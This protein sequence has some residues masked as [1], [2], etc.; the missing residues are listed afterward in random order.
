MILISIFIQIN[1][2]DNETSIKK[3]MYLMIENIKRQNNI[4]KSIK[5]TRKYNHV[6]AKEFIAQSI[7]S[8]QINW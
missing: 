7:A 4:K 5:L 8:V 1:S 3:F 6:I 2:T